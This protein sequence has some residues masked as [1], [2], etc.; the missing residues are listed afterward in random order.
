MIFFWFMR[1]WFK[2][3][4]YVELLW[5]IPILLA[6]KPFQAAALPAAAMAI[7]E[8]RPEGK[9]AS[10]MFK[11]QVPPKASNHSQDSGSR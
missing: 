4:P 9:L 3:R 7:A 8:A 11:V 10:P 2:S 1:R 6:A 5:S